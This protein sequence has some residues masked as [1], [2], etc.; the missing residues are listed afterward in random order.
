VSSSKNKKKDNKPKVQTSEVT[1]S[2]SKVKPRSL[3]DRN[4]KPAAASSPQVLYVVDS[5]SIEIDG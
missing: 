1:T 5:D 2:S 4:T 3:A